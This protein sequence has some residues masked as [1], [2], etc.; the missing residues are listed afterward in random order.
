MNWVFEKVVVQISIKPRMEGFRCRYELYI[1]SEFESSTLLDFRKR[2]RVTSQVYLN[3][4]VLVVR[5]NQVALRVDVRV[6][7]TNLLILQIFHVIQ[8]CKI[9]LLFALKVI[10]LWEHLSNHSPY[11][12]IVKIHL[13]KPAM[14]NG[15]LK[16]LCLVLCQWFGRTLFWF[17]GS[18]EYNVIT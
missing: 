18:K 17:F 10:C 8:S 7:I 9:V 4:L 6:K 16:L 15:A 12:Q 5:N 11:W 1:E 3:N 14:L 13:I 2:P